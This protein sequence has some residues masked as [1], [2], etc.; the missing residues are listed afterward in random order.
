MADPLAT[1][2]QA[3]D[4]NWTSSAERARWLAPEPRVQAMVSL[5]RA[6][7]FS[8]VLDV[9]CGIGRHARYLAGEGF[10]CAGIDASQTGLDFARHEAAA[11]GL[12]I[13]FREAAFYELPFEAHSFDGL[14]AWNVIYHG[15]G[16]VVQRAIDEFA[17]VLVPGGVYVGTLLSRRN[18]AYGRGREVRPDTFVV[19]DATDDKVHPHFYA[20]AASLLKLHRGFEILDLRDHEETPGANHWQFTFER[21]G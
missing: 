12:Q 7:G 17:R 19:Y 21:Q 8:R 4:R 20:D 1:A 16:E 3:W 14:I 2:H 11:A 5:L 6:R 18:R 13:D 15:D 9:G 10:T